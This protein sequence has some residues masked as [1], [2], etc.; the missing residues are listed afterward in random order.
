VAEAVAVQPDGKIVVAG[1]SVDSHAT[2]MFAL[3]RYLADGTLDQTFGDG[4]KVTSVVGEAGSAATALALRPDGKIVVGGTASTLQ[5]GVSTHAFALARYDAD[6]SLDAGFGSNGQVIT[7]LGEDDGIHDLAIGKDAKI[8]AAGDS[9]VASNDDFALARYNPN[10]SLDRRFG[11]GGR[12]RTR[13]S[14]EDDA[15]HAVSVQRNG[16]VVA[17]GYSFSSAKGQDEV[18]LVRYLDKQPVCL[19]PNLKGHQLRTARQKIRRAHCSIGRLRFAGSRTR[20]GTVIRQ[21]PEPGS[22]EPARTRINLV[23]SG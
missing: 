16:K 18:A 11:K 8:L 3:A 2:T 10:G 6:G 12:I 9:Y 5:G 19:V 14:S 20:L 22:R 15:A 13:L 4:G 23:V 21:S 17:A 1:Y 7:R